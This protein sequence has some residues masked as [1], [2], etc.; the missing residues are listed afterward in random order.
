MNPY[1]TVQPVHANWGR[2]SPEPEDVPCV[3]AEH[4]AEQQ[5]TCNAAA[6]A[7]VRATVDSAWSTIIDGQSISSTCAN[8]ELISLSGIQNHIAMV[9]HVKPGC[10]GNAPPPLIALWHTMVG[11]QIVLS[12]DLKTISVQRAVSGGMNGVPVF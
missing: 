8:S 1:V 10:H 5:E 7:Y 3:A 11:D 4:A 12:A 2:A 6:R 9:T